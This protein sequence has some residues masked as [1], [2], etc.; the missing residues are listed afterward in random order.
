MASLERRIAI[1]SN[2]ISRCWR[3]AQFLSV[4]EKRKSGLFSG[5]SVIFPE[6]S[7][8]DA[9]EFALFKQWFAQMAAG[10]ETEKCHVS[11]SA[12]WLSY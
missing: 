12:H 3:E 2:S 7:V 5:I 11:A 4:R 6:R 10:H 8:V 9:Q 1:S